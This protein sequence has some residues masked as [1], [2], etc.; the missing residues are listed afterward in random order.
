[1]ENVKP[2]DSLR[3]ELKAEESALISKLL[4]FQKDV[5]TTELEL[6][7]VQLKIGK[8]PKKNKE[9]IQGRR[10]FLSSGGREGQDR[11]V[12]NGSERGVSH[13]KKPKRMKI[14]LSELRRKR[15]KIKHHE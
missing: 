5:A 4:N 2:K 13:L 8:I 3:K 9:R 7:R 15:N 6:R 12:F 10:V 1:M 14:V 11:I